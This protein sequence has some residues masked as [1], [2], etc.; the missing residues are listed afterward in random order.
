MSDEFD[1]KEDFNMYRVE[2]I[3]KECP[4][5]SDLYHGY[6]EGRLHSQ[7]RLKQTQ[8]RLEEC[9]EALS[10]YADPQTYNMDSCSVE[11]DDELIS[12]ITES[13]WEIGNKTK[14]PMQDYVGGKRARQYF[15]KYKGGK[16]EHNTK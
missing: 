16:D 6:K 13:Q 12:Y 14:Y 11:D 5:C 8:Q 15:E 1:F 7:L 10:F 3:P 9:E 4:F 2:R